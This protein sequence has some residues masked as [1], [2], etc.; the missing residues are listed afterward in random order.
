MN[1]HIL[2]E[3]LVFSSLVLQIAASE[4]IFSDAFEPIT[5]N[6]S[7]SGSVKVVGKYTPHYGSVWLPNYQYPKGGLLDSTRRQLHFSCNSSATL[8]LNFGNKY[9]KDITIDFWRAV[10]NVETVD[11][12][13]TLSWKG[14]MWHNSVWKRCGV[15]HD[16]IADEYG[17]VSTNGDLDSQAGHVTKV[18]SSSTLNKIK[19]KF[20]FR[21]YGSNPDADGGFIDELKVS[22]DLAYDCSKEDECQTEGEKRC[23]GNTVQECGNCDNDPCLE[24]CDVE[25]CTS[26]DPCNESFCDDGK[27][28]TKE[29]CSLASCTSAATTYCNHKNCHCNDDKQNCDETGIDCGGS[30]EPCGGDINDGLPCEKDSDC[31]SNRCDLGDTGKCFHCAICPGT[32][33]PDAVTSC[34]NQEPGECEYQCGADQA[35]D[36]KLMNSHWISDQACRSCKDCLYSSDDTVDLCSCS[37]SNCSGGYCDS[38]DTCYYGVEC[39][40]DG[41]SY[42]STCSTADSCDANTL[43][44]GK[45]CG[46]GGCSSGATY[47]CDDTTHTNCQKV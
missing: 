25:T 28:V 24:W 18:L 4:T 9:Y 35:C 29:N 20:E 44:T 10:R 17:Y 26:T 32:S 1:R 12:C 6:W 33:E 23:S 30:C 21:G 8:D 45:T 40:I 2:F 36:D 43:V 42:N 27:C 34:S 22:G 7:T 38:G 19:I 16:N 15:G 5:D 41:W 31:I 13:L 11:E 37:A 46:A 14:D 47:T 39:G 3:L